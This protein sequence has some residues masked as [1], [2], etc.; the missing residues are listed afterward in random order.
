MV[1][2]DAPAA[3][4][5]RGRRVGPVRDRRG[6]PPWRAVGNK[7]GDRDRTQE[8][9]AAFG[10][11]RGRA[12][13]AEGGPGYGATSRPPGIGLDVGGRSALGSNGH[14]AGLEADDDRAVAIGPQ[15][16]CARRG[17]PIQGRLGRVAIRVAGTR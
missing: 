7:P 9:Q 3:G 12:Q 1:P 13:E 16:A 6:R 10:A 8:R 5:C 17:E 4:M 15:D 2:D 11:R 14:V